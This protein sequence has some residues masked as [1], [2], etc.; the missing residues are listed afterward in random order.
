MLMTLA[1]A[2]KLGTKGLT[3]VSLHPGVIQTNL[4]SHVDWTTEFADLCRWDLC[5]QR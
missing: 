2:L 3:A 1:L 5:A 4:S